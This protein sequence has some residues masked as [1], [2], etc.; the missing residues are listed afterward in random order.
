MPIDY[1]ALLSQI[2]ENER[3]LRQKQA[4]QQQNLQLPLG[5]KSAVMKEGYPFPFNVPAANAAYDATMNLRE[6]EMEDL[7]K[8]LAALLTRGGWNSNRGY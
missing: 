7:K 1:Q 4:L 6:Q 8:R 2:D 3:L 5:G